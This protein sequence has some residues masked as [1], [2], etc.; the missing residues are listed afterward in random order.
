MEVCEL[1]VERA[2]DF[3][4]VNVATALR[5]VLQSRRDGVP[6]QLVE[7]AQH[8][9]EA[10]ALRMIDEFEAHQVA[11]TLHIMAKTH[12]RPWDPSLVPALEVRAEAVA[13]TFNTQS[14]ANTLWAYATMGREPE[15]GVMRELAGRA[16]ALAGTFNAQNVAN[17][18]W[19]YATMRREPGA[20]LMRV[21][22]GRAE[23]LAGTFNA[24]NV[25]NKFNTQEVANTLWRRLCYMCSDGICNCW[26]T[27]SSGCSTWNGASGKGHAR[28]SSI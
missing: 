2:A 15:A 11:S 3:N 19:A 17:T 14:L 9:L 21:L 25:A 13:D 1:I 18:L 27:L 4:H 10:A 28:G 8:A 26:A 6:H 20:G 16:E 5:T 23:A 7:K 24:Q 12:Y 22:E